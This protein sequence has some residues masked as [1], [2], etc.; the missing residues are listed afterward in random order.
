L[1]LAVFPDRISIA[2][3][4]FIKVYDPHGNLPQRLGP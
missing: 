3:G 4:T 1:N 2:A